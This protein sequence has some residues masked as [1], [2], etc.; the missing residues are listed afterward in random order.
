MLCELLV[1]NYVGTFL[2]TC[3]RQDFSNLSA[4]DKCIIIMNLGRLACAWAQS[5]CG[6]EYGNIAGQTYMC[7]VCNDE[8]E[9]CYTK[10]PISPLQFGYLRSIIAGILPRIEDSGSCR[11]SAMIAIRNIVNHDLRD[12]EDRLDI[13]L[14]GEYC[15][16]SLKSSIRELRVAAGLVQIIMT[17]R[18]NTLGLYNSNYHVLL[19]KH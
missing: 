8:V 11:I 4:A 3:F 7:K 16:R 9:K 19:G 12:T 2:L 13:S 15:L 5:L 10:K 14:F 1:S 18:H 17:P 6:E